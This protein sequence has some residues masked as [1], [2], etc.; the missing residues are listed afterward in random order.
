MKPS[1]FF[2][3]QVVLENELAFAVY[4]AFPVGAGHLLIV[5]KRL[6]SDYFAARAAEVDALWDLV[7][8]AKKYLDV[9]YKSDGYNIGINSGEAAGQTV[10]HLH[11]HVI[12]RYKGDIDDPRG[13]V[14]GVIPEKR[15]YENA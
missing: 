15:I 8:R 9:E 10:G 12:P 5:P 6:F 4:D 13:G 2:E 3:M 7:N 14:R 11:I 1:P